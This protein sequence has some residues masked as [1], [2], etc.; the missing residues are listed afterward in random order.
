N[1]LKTKAK[2]DEKKGK[3]RRASRDRG[4]ASSSSGAGAAAAAALGNN[5]EESGGSS[6]SGPHGGRDQGGSPGA[7]SHRAPVPLTKQMQ[8]PLMQTP[9]AVMEVFSFGDNFKSVPTEDGQEI[10]TMQD[11]TIP[12]MLR[13]IPKMYYFTQPQ[14]PRVE[15]ARASNNPQDDRG[16]G[17]RRSNRRG[18]EESQGAVAV[19]SPASPPQ[20]HPTPELPAQISYYRQKTPSLRFFSEAELFGVSQDADVNMQRLLINRLFSIYDLTGI[21]EKVQLQFDEEDV[22][23]DLPEKMKKLTVGFRIFG[24][25]VIG[26]KRGKELQVDQ[27]VEDRQQQEALACTLKGEACVTGTS[28]SV[29]NSCHS[30]SYCQGVLE[31]KELEEPMQQ[32]GGAGGAFGGGEQVAQR[33]QHVGNEQ[34]PPPGYV[35]PLTEDSLPRKRYAI[36]MFVS[37]NEGIKVPIWYSPAAPCFMFVGGALF[38]R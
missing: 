32:P 21:W 16:R 20:P 28:S 23:E 12:V 1:G 11:R 3:S 17:R 5:S 31:F 18:G 15:Q 26:L 35:D 38:L 19:Q 10:L 14:P 30:T 25:R 13:R 29:D 4:A 22:E 2:E 9:K 27:T 34:Q 33:P 6:T 36:S 8:L 24:D 37:G 7:L